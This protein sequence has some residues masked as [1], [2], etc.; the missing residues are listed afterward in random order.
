MVVG[1][2]SGDEYER[3]SAV[4][5]YAENN[6][7]SGV[8]TEFDRPPGRPNPNRRANMTTLLLLLFFLRGPICIQ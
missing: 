4:V 2:T 5:S 7:K 6:T 8:R 3:K 1:L